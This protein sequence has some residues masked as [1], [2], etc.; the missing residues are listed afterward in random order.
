MR[1]FTPGIAKKG[2]AEDGEKRE[3]VQ[4]ANLLYD[5]LKEKAEIGEVAGVRMPRFW[6]Y[7]SSH[8]GK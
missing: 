3:E 8:P 1:Y 6:T 2:D 4:A 5:T 7:Y